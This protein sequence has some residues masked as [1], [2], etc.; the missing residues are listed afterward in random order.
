MKR[1]LQIGIGIALLV[2]FVLWLVLKIFFSSTA[3][4]QDQGI[5]NQNTQSTY[6]YSTGASGAGGGTVQ[7]G[8]LISV[9]TYDN[10]TIQ[11]KDFKGDPVTVQD[12]VNKGHY[13]IGPHP[14]EGV[15]DPTASDN[16][17]YIIEYIDADGSF[18]ISLRAEPISKT[19]L[20]V[21]KFLMQHLGLNESQMCQL[22]FTISVPNFVNSYYAG[23]DLG[24]SFCP[25]ATPL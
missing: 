7:G 23:T 19:R 15:P 13:L 11:V 21:E 1:A 20:D 9:A 2:G 12:P 18:T 22:K 16:P 25:G 10:K 3:S 5:Q 6:T 8:G 17:P 24:F 4:V 14:Y